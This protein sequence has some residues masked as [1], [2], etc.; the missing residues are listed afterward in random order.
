MSLASDTVQSVKSGI[1]TSAPRPDAQDKVQGDFIF[2]SDLSSDGM[3]WGQTLRSPHASAKILSIDISEALTISGV[4]AILTADDVPGK[5]IFGLERTDQ[6]VLASDCVRYVGEPIA[7]VAADHPEIARK[8][9]DAIRVDY[10]ILSPLI[11]SYLAIAADPI[12]PEGNVIRHL[13]IRHG[14]SEATGDVA[15]EGEYEI[16]MQDQA[17]MGT[18]SGMAIPTQDGGIELHISTQ[19][20]HSDQEQV[21]TAL[22]MPKE[23]VRVTLSGVGGAFGGREDVSM[24]VHLCMLALHTGKPVKMIYDRNES[25]L[26]HVHR[27]PAKVWFRHHANNDGALVN[28]EAKIIMDGGAYA[29]TTSAVLAN[30]CCF[31]IG[32]YKVQNAFVEGWALRT[33]NPP[34]GAMRGFGNVQTCFAAEALSLI[35]I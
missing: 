33:N 25:F 17:F 19:W 26:G 23:L 15:V 35:H 10:A 32:P 5:N 27:H 7:I 29:S 22:N 18:E 30:A 14:D 34:C 6:P 24:H 20:L 2:S 9:T 13:T 28:V 4:H 11:D 12:H 8:A 3:L 21:A 31:S 1:G 16:G